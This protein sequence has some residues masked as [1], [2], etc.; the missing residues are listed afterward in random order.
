MEKKIFKIKVEGGRLRASIFNQRGTELEPMMYQSL[1]KDAIESLAFVI[2]Q[3]FHKYPNEYTVYFN[4]VPV[5]QARDL[6]ELIDQYIQRQR[7]K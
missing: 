1:S 7:W 5:K 4:D 6:P 3:I 2:K